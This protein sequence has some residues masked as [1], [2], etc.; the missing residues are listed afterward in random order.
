MLKIGIFDLLVLLITTIFFAHFFACIFRFMANNSEYAKNWVHVYGINDKSLEDQYLYSLY[1]STVTMMTVGYGDIV[2]QN[3]SE[4]FFSVIAILVGCI[5]VGYNISKIGNIFQDMNKEE[6]KI[7]DNIN[8]LN[9]FMKAKRINNNLQMRIRAYLKFLSE[10]Q[11]EKLNNDLLKIIDTLSDSLKEELYLQGYGDIIRNYNL[12]SNNFSYECL[13]TLI[14]YMKEETFMKND[15]ILTENENNK[16]NLYFIILGEI[17]IFRTVSDNSPSIILK[18]LKEKESFGEYSFL[19]GKNNYYSAKASTYSQ[20]YKISHENFIEVLSKFPKDYEKY[21]EIR[22]K[23]NFYKGYE[24]YNL[25]C[26]ICNKKDHINNECR[27]MHYIPNKE[28]IL[29]KHLFTQDQ[30]RKQYK[31]KKILN[32]NALNEKTKIVKKIGKFMSNSHFKENEDDDSFDEI[33]EIPSNDSPKNK[34]KKKYSFNNDKEEIPFIKEEYSNKKPFFST[35]LQKIELNDSFSIDDE[36][37]ANLDKLINSLYT[38][39][40]PESKD[41]VLD[42]DHAKKYEFYFPEGNYKDFMEKN[43]RIRA[44]HRKSI[45][46]H[47]PI[48]KQVLFKR[49]QT[50]GYALFQNNLGEKSQNKEKLNENVKLKSFLNRNNSHMFFMKKESEKPKTFMQLIE[51]A[52]E[53]KNKEKNKN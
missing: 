1:W 24:S 38:P 9:Q 44:I 29:L 7:Q 52:K 8:K 43:E 15:V 2:A 50:R 49:E 47:K 4:M 23:I 11:H 14:R 51:E 36:N 19:T 21:S 37:P 13:S 41:F 10:K 27:L 35:K 12:F 48:D 20:V 32:F 33:E 53:K 16:K 30:P 45:R 22:D 39:E 25:R 28:N 3:P 6:K 17:E 26:V 42:I 34:N 5:I 31:R 40:K 18:K 46:K